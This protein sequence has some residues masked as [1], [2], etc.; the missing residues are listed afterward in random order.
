MAQKIYCIGAFLSIMLRTSSV[1]AK[2]QQ[3]DAHRLKSQE[4]FQG[5]QK[6]ER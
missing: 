6:G 2:Q 4:A 3:W 1:H 5:F